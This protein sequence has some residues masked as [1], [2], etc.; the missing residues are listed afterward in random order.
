[1]SQIYNQLGLSDTDCPLVYPFLDSPDKEI[2][3]FSGTL[4]GETY[5]IDSNIEI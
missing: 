1:M 3:P 5:T 2:S 4:D